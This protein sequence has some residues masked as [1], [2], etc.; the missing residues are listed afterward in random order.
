L[1]VPPQTLNDERTHENER[2][3]LWATLPLAVQRELVDA[4]SMMLAAALLPHAKEEGH[5]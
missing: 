1:A 2:Q 3:T 5:E 4:V